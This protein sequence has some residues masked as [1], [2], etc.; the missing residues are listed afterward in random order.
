MDQVSSQMVDSR[1]ISD[2]ISCFGAGPNFGRDLTS[3]VAAVYLAAGAFFSVKMAA[4]DLTSSVAAMYHAAGA[5][6]SVKM[7]DLDLTSS[8]AAMCLA[9]GAFF[10]VKMTTCG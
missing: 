7:A 4:L 5:F 2:Q 8:V 6:F 3:P 10:P 1:P 9:A